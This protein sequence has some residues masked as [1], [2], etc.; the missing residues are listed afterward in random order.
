[1]DPLSRFKATKN[2]T[3]TG[4]ENVLSDCS[5]HTSDSGSLAFGEHVVG[6]HVFSALRTKSQRFTLSG[7][8]LQY[9][10]Q[11]LTFKT[12]IGNSVSPGSNLHKVPER[13]YG[14]WLQSG[15]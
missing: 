15:T 9:I 13:H 14:E 3:A 10:T 8:L 7:I 12:G 5:Y 1:M 2:S 11:H 6:G 4:G